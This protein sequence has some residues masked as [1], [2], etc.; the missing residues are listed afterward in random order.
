MALACLDGEILLD[1]L[2]LIV[3]AAF[4]MAAVIIPAFIFTLKGYTAQSLNSERHRRS[5][6]DL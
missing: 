5:S 2:V 4:F 1:F 3:A 6:T